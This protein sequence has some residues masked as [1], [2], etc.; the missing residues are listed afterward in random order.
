MNISSNANV[1]M[2]H[3]GKLYGKKWTFITKMP[4]RI[5]PVPQPFDGIETIASVFGKKEKVY[6][7]KKKVAI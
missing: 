6:L 3:H 5:E 7:P 4:E 2:I 1:K